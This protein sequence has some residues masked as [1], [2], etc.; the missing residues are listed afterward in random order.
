M[1]SKQSMVL[2]LETGMGVTG[3]GPF[4]LLLLIFFVLSNY[5]F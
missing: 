1:V 4:P 2:P 5:Y 3:K